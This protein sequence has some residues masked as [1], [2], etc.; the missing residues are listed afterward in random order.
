MKVKNGIASSVSFG[1]DA[2]DALRQRLQQRRLQQA[3]LD[4]D[5][6]EEQAVGGQREGDR[7]AEQQEDDQRAEHDRRHVGGDEVRSFRSAL[8]LGLRQ[9]SSASSSS[10]RLASWRL[11]RDPASSPCR[12]AMRL[13][14]SDT[15]CSA[16]SAKPTGSSTYTGQ[17][18]RPPALLDISAAA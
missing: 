2:E 10:A 7:I 16:S 9:M 15:P 1:H 12:K 6:A 3:E 8:R 11:R 4:A 5:Q 17:R 14:S 13:I 18:I